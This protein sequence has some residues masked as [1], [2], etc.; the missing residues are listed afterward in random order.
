MRVHGEKRVD[1]IVKKGRFQRAEGGHAKRTS[2]EEVGKSMS[3]KVNAKALQKD[4]ESLGFTPILAKSEMRK[5]VGRRR[6][7]S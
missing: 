7:R 6:A 5:K 1:S 3:G 4:R 2:L